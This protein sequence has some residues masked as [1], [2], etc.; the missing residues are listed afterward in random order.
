MTDALAQALDVEALERLPF[1]DCKDALGSAWRGFQR[2]TLLDAWSIGCVLR[3]LKNQMQRREFGA[4]ITAAR[5]RPASWKT[6]PS[7]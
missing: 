6:S 1:E 7:R 5:T 3:S 4:Y 2:R